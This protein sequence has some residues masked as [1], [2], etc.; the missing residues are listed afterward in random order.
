MVLE[1]YKRLWHVELETSDFFHRIF[2]SISSVIFK[3]RQKLN[4][5]V[6]LKNHELGETDPIMK[7]KLLKKKEG[8]ES[9]F[10]SHYQLFNE[11]LDE[12][13]FPENTKRITSCLLSKRP[14][15][16]LHEATKALDRLIHRKRYKYK[17]KKALRQTPTANLDERQAEF[18]DLEIFELEDL[19]SDDELCLF[20][21][22]MQDPSSVFEFVSGIRHPLSGYWKCNKTKLRSRTNFGRKRLVNVQLKM[23][24]KLEQAEI[25]L[26]V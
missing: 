14:Y 10:Y 3:S 7:I 22:L 19:F 11:V 4:A 9:Y 18:F 17:S 8:Q 24:K 13:L 20:Q 5:G 15:S 23:K 21:I 26:S 2:M 12:M 6:H 25:F 16:I 1:Q